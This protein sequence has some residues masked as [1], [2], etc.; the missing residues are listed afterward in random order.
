MERPSSSW[1]Y[2]AGFLTVFHGGNKYELG[3]F[4]LHQDARAAALAFIAGRGDRK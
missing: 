1:K 2:E 3:Y 4:K